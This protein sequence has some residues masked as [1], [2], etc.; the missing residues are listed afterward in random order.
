M[1]QKKQY[2]KKPNNNRP[3]F[4]RGSVTSEQ[5]DY[6]DHKLL[7]NFFGSRNQIVPRRYSKLTSKLQR[8]LAN[9]VKKARTMGLLKYTERH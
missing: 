3:K 7:R 2:N 1:E 4:D 5:I 8:K 9:E 6:K